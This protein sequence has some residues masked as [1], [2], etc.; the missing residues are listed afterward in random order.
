MVIKDE[1]TDRAKIITKGALEEMLSVSKYVEVD[2][3]IL[4]I[5]DK[6]LSKIHKEARKL[7]NEGMRVIGVSRKDDQD[8]EKRF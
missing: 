1:L 2:G 4:E 8:P 3:Q 7:N 5:N 6:I